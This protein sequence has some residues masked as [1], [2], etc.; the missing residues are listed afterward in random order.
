MKVYRQMKMYNDPATNPVLDGKKGMTPSPAPP[1]PGR[2][3]LWRVS[4]LLGDVAISIP[5]IHEVCRACSDIRFIFSDKARDDRTVCQRSG[6]SPFSPSI[7]RSTAARQDCGDLPHGSQGI[8]DQHFR[9]PSRRVAH[10]LLRIFRTS[11]CPVRQY[12]QR[13][14]GETRAHTAAAQTACTAEKL[15]PSAI[16]KL[17]PRRHPAPG[18][19]GKRRL[20]L[21]FGSSRHRICA[22]AGP[23]K[24]SPRCRR[25][26]QPENIGFA[27]APFA[28]HKGRYILPD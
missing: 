4:P 24:L 18:R 5:L 9:G 2:P 14:H 15:P 10:E 1:C 17:W 3:C 26:K 20:L 8:R 23:W 7:S 16:W 12:R 28:A 11:R 27:V 22:G 13:P 6:Q 25:Q 19:R 21:L